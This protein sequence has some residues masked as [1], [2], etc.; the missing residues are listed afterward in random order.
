M[1]NRNFND[2]S[3]KFVIG[4]NCYW[5]STNMDFIDLKFNYSVDHH[6]SMVS[7]PVHA[8]LAI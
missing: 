6:L 3:V 4:T 5:F 8:Q 7:Q 2:S 1:I